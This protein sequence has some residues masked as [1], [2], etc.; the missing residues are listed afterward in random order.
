VLGRWFEFAAVNV[1]RNVEVIGS[2]MRG[3]GNC[4]NALLRDLRPAELF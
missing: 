1:E 2:K 4:G 3:E